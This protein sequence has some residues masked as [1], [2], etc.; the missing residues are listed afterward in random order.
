MLRKAV[1]D[2][3]R[4]AR[5]CAIAAPRRVVSDDL[6]IL[7]SPTGWTAG[8]GEWVRLDGFPRTIP[9]AASLD[10]LLVDGVVSVSSLVVHADE[11]IRRL[12]GRDATTMRVRHQGGLSVYA[13]ETQPVPILS[14]R[15]S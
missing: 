5:L 8:H 6:I 10:A 2:G 1:K 12:A 15:M 4:C 11:V 13:R 3:T 7:S 14:R 9:Q